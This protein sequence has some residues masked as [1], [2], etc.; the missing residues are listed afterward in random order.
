MPNRSA[1]HEE[2]SGANEAAI[3]D[4]SLAD[5]DASAA[6]EDTTGTMREKLER[7]S[8]AQMELVQRQNRLQAQLQGTNQEQ[9]SS[10][11]QTMNDNATSDEAEAFNTA[12]DAGQEICNNESTQA[13]SIPRAAGEGSSLA[14][15]C[16]QFS[17]RGFPCHGI[18]DLR[19][20]LTA[21]GENGCATRGLALATTTLLKTGSAGVSAGTN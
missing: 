19:G 5:D 1:G 14:G 13:P 3:S 7:L 8:Q 21:W 11:D 6:S 2:R 9:E 10:Q 16:M 20:L 15:D 17:G 18:G 4:G 12:S